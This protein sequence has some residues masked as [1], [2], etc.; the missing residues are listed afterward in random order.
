M[1]KILICTLMVIGL[2]CSTIGVIRI[3]GLFGLIHLDKASVIALAGGIIFLMTGGIVEQLSIPT[4]SRYGY[5][6]RARIIRS[7]VYAITGCI[8]MII[9]ALIFL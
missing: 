8:I 2:V 1:K 5:R 4:Y 6:N 7:C 3:L 9:A